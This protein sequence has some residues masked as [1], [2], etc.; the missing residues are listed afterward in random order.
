MVADLVQS[1]HATGCT[2]FLKM[3]FLDPH[4]D[5]FPENL[6]AESDERGKR[7]HQTISTMEMLSRQV[8]SLYA[9]W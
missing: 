8:E 5:F 7:F 6:G 3:P 4:L 9:D 1:Q 2:I